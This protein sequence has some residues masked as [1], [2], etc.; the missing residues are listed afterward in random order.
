MRELGVPAGCKLLGVVAL[1]FPSPEDRPRG[2]VFARRRRAFE[3]M[4][5]LERW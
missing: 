3:D 2:S 1:G 5:H 4:F